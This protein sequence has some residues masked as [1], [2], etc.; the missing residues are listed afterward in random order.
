MTPTHK[1]MPVVDADKC[2]GCELCVNACGPKCLEMQLGLAVLTVPEA[3]GSEEHCI[4]LCADD[5][6]HMAWLPW[7]GNASRGKWRSLPQPHPATRVTKVTCAS[8][9]ELYD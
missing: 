6:I 3:S 1:W 8:S 9:G 7:I 4:G 5:A 2:S